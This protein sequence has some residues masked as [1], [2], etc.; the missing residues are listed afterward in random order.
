VVVSVV[1]YCV[2][3]K[4]VYLFMLIALLVY[5]LYILLS[6]NRKKDRLGVSEPSFNLYNIRNDGR[7]LLKFGWC[8]FIKIHIFF[9]KN[10]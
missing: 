3:S 6:I 1:V 9:S 2:V 7:S 5:T 10:E 8:E 4:N